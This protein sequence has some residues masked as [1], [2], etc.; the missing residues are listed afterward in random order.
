MRR[1]PVLAIIMFSLGGGGETTI[2]IIVTRIGKGEGAR[3]GARITLV[4]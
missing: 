2:M 4:G 3:K 1:C